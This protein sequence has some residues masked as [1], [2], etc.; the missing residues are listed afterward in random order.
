M[1]LWRGVKQ[2]NTHTFSMQCLIFSFYKIGT[3]IIRVK[4]LI[5]LTIYCSF[6]F[7]F[8][9]RRVVWWMLLPA[10]WRLGT[11]STGD[12]LALVHYGVKIRVV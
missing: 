11:T 10:Y 5:G 4:E 12:G 8:Q 2:P 1:P 6:L 9:I 3:G 7:C